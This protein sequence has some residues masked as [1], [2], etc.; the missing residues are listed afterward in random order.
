MRSDYAKS[1]I[2]VV[3]FN[4]TKNT[5]I[6]G[7]TYKVFPHR[8]LGKKRCFFAQAKCRGMRVNHAQWTSGAQDEIEKGV[9]GGRSKKP[10]KMVTVKFNY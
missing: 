3:R 10:E 2:I 1:S 4:M 6:D 8:R 7:S 9:E 5:G